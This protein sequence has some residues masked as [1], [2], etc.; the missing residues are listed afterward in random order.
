V[1]PA[2]DRPV[3]EALGF[4]MSST[5]IDQIA[6]IEDSDVSSWP[7]PIDVVAHADQGALRQWA[8]R[9]RARGH[10][11]TWHALPDQFEW[12]AEEAMNTALVPQPALQCLLGVIQAEAGRK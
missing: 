3:G 6:C 11:C 1:S 4:A 7:G 8:E 12:T 2:G 5:L 9:E 10:P